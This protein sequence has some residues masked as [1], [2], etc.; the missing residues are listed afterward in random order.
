MTWIR[1]YIDVKQLDMFNRA[2]PNITAYILTAVS[3]GT[4]ASAIA[5]YI[6]NLSG[7]DRG[8]GEVGHS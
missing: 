4:R 1:Y 3:I 7:A 5:S 6:N 8:C 2:N